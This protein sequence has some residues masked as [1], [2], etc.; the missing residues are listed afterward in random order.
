MF[1]RNWFITNFLLTSVLYDDLGFPGGLVGLC[2][3]MSFR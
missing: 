3:F 2:P 1:Q